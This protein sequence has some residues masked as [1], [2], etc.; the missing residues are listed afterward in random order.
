[1]IFAQGDTA[2]SLHSQS[3]GTISTEKPCGESASRSA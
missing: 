1:V 3:Y 2:R